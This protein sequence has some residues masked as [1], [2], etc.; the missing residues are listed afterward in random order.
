MCETSMIP[1]LVARPNSEMNRNNAAIE[2][3]QPAANAPTMPPISASGSLSYGTDSMV[4]M[5]LTTYN[6]HE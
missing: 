5:N 6:G 1:F 4:R 2:S 3:T